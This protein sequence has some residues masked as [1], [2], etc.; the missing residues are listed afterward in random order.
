MTIYY[1]KQEIERLED[2]VDQKD[3]EIE[4]LKR[5]IDSLQYEL[6]ELQ[7]REE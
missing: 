3:N 7:N 6:L 5:G 4:D 1:L 2:L